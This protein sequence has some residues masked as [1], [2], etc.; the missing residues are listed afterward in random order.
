MDTAINIR[1]DKKTRDEAKKIFMQMG[2]ST[3]A[4]INL[5]LRQV[6]T[7][8]G[9][10]FTPSVNPEAIKARWDSQVADA[11]KNGKKYTRAQDALSN[12]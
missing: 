8:K 3:S 4:G 12:K 5:F 7:E 2:L 11:V 1:T 10:P 9:M 6:I